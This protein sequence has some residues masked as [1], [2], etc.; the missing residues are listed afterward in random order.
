[1]EVHHLSCH[2]CKRT[3]IKLWRCHGSYPSQGQL[4]CTLHLSSAGPDWPEHRRGPGVPADIIISYVPA[5][6][7]ASNG[8]FYSITCV[9][10]DDA[11][12]WRLLPE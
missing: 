1:M 4:L 11:E 6:Y 5:V 9:P 8:S 2:T 3:N 12:L 10:S 7:D